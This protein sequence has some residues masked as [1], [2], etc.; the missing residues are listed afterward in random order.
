MERLKNTTVLQKGN[1]YF[2][3]KGKEYWLGT[4][5]KEWLNDRFF[6]AYVFDLDKEAISK[7]QKDRP[8]TF[9][10]FIPGVDI[11]KSGY[12]QAFSNLPSFISD[13]VADPRMGMIQYYL[14]RFNMKEYDAFTMLLRN[15]GRSLD[16]FRVEEIEV[17][18]NQ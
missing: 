15:H 18:N 11:D 9:G 17:S 8:N 12:Y 16:G 10:D 5:S 4:L 3:Y 13:R 7:L 2:D 1:L 6:I 14:D